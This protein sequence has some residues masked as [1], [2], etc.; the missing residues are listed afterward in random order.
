MISCQR[1]CNCCTVATCLTTQIILPWAG[2]QLDLYAWKGP[3]IKSLKSNLTEKLM[4]HFYATPPPPPP[5]PQKKKKKRA[6]ESHSLKLTI[7]VKV[8]VSSMSWY[9][10]SQVLQ[11]FNDSFVL[12]GTQILQ[13]LPISI[14][15]ND[16]HQLLKS[17]INYLKLYN[18]LTTKKLKH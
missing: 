9:F 12:T 3:S 2:G 4:I 16:F 14:N 13:L 5:P 1:E 11:T 15:K 8:H 6:T 10:C 18:S 7:T 17:C